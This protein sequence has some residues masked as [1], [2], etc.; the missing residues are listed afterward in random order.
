MKH[1]IKIIPNARDYF[2]LELGFFKFL[3][4]ELFMPGLHTR[5]FP[6]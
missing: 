6:C 3:K 2:F 5:P 4:A 1:E